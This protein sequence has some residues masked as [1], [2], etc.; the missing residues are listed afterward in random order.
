MSMDTTN[1]ICITYYFYSL[2]MIYRKNSSRVIR[3][4]ALEERG[5]NPA[6]SRPD[7]A[8]SGVINT[9]QLMF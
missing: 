8:K 9:A 6:L 5:G 7:E 4:V 1:N 3:K 2:E